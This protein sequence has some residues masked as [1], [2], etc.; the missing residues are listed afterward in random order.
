MGVEVEEIDDCL[1][2][3]RIGKLRKTNIKTMPYPGFPTDMQPQMAA[4][5]CLAEGTSIVTESV[6]ASRFRYVE[7]FK[8]MGA[9]I[10]VNENLA[11]IDGVEQLT[12]AQMQACDLRA[13][14]AM[15]I[16]ALAANGRSEITG[17][18]YIERGYE[19]V[20]EKFR[21]LG[22]NIVSVEVPDEEEALSAG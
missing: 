6:W 18:Q 12:G 20:I 5:L 22:G 19:N 21:N 7:E 4:A 14:A 13:G 17:V 2:V 9:Q 11:I 8:R 10:Q 1:L 15:I 3:R 16:V